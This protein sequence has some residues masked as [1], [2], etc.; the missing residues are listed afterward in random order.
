MMFIILELLNGYVHGAIIVNY[1]LDLN[2]DSDYTIISLLMRCI[3][4]YDKDIVYRD[5]YISPYR[6]TSGQN[7]TNIL[8]I[9]FCSN[10]AIIFDT[11]KRQKLCVVLERFSSDSLL[12]SS[13]NET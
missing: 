5:E 3:S 10:M 8:D 1:A 12:Y 7:L 6:T 4:Q 9:I 11:N 2:K 13:G